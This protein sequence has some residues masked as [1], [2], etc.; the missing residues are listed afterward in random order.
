MLNYKKSVCKQVKLLANGLAQ[1]GNENLINTCYK[2]LESK[3]PESIRDNL[4][5]QAEKYGVRPR[6][7]TT[8]R[9]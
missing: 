7:R 1:V 3:D 4:H 9:K 5:D 6:M 8:I 2:S